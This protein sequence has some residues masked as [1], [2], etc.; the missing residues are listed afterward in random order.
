MAKTDTVNLDTLNLTNVDLSLPLTMRAIVLIEPNESI[1]L[2][3][4]ILPLPECYRCLS[5]MIM[6]CW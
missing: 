6:S 1:S 2:S 5:V 4:A 3:E